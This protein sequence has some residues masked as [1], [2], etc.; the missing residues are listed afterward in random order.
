[1]GYRVFISHSGEDTWV[2]KMVA[3]ECK[4]AGADIFLDETQIAVGAKFEQDIL[5]ALR[6][7]DELVALITP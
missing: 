2:A 4:A 6:N 7:A 3:L 1:M 5:I